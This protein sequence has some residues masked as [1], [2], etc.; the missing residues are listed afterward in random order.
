MIQVHQLGLTG[1]LT[2]SVF[3]ILVQNPEPKIVKPFANLFQLF[4]IRPHAFASVSEN[5]FEKQ[6][7]LNSLLRLIKYKNI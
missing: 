3:T 1:G 5:S 4:I 6:Q 7:E 2:A